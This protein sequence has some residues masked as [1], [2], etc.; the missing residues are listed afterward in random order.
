MFKNALIYRIESWDAPASAAIEDRL[1]GQRFIECGASQPESAG[2]VEPRGRKHGALLEQVAGQTILRLCVE[3]KAVPASVVKTLLEE[4]LQKIED[5]TGRRP[6]GKHAKEM[7]EAIVH[8]L[9]P[10]AFAKRLH[11]LVWLDVKAGLVLV[12]AGSVKKADALVTRLI[13]LLGGGMRL[14]LLQTQLSP[15]AGMAE[16]LATH[17]A[18]AGFSID[19]ECE[20]KQPDSEKA[21]VR[22]A[23]HALDID[24]LALHI[25]QGKLPTQVAM[26]WNGRVSFVLTEA[27]T[28]KKIKLLDVVLEGTPAPQGDDG[29]DADVALCT[30]E[31]RQLIPDLV[32]ALG[33]E[34]VR[35]AIGAPAQPAGTRAEPSLV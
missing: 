28:L 10:R 9:L 18:P 32:A 20:L 35:D 23:R 13:E 12:D 33:G 24:E 22:Y 25:Q 31:L 14:A 1:A 6:R 34:Q 26:T 4:Q 7:K 15:V 21:T 16:W 2:W 19:R 8:G 3:R 30:G 11:T 27:L 17:E 5:D 29:F